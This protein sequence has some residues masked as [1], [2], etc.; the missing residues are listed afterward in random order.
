MYA[1]IA[2]SGAAQLMT[3]CDDVERPETPSL[4][5]EIHFVTKAIRHSDFVIPSSFVIG[6]F[7]ILCM[8]RPM[9]SNGDLAAQCRL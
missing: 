5:P 8:R 9:I 1:I 7:V 2:R 3:K 4:L 6:C